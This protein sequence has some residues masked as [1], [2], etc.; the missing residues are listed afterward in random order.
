MKSE[1]KLRDPI[2]ALPQSNSSWH[3]SLQEF[4]PQPGVYPSETPK[5]VM[6]AARV[7]KLWGETALD[8]C[9]NDAEVR[10]KICRQQLKARRQVYLQTFRR[11]RA[12][13]CVDTPMPSYFLG[14]ASEKDYQIG[15]TSR[16]PLT[17]RN[18]LS[19][20]VWNHKWGW[21]LDDIKSYGG[22]DSAKR[23]YG[24][25]Q[26]G[27]FWEYDQRYAA[28]LAGGVAQYDSDDGACFVDRFTSEEDFHDIYTFVEEALL[29]EQGELEALALAEEAV[30]RDEEMLEWCVANLDGENG[31]PELKLFQE[32][33]C[34]AEDEM[35]GVC[36]PVCQS[37]ILTLGND[38]S[39]SC[40]SCCLLLD[41]DPLLSM[42]TLQN[43]TERSRQEHVHKGC[44][45]TPKFHVDDSFGSRLLL[46][47]CDG[48]GL[49]NVCL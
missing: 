34:C 9:S 28:E 12:T 18:Y 46:I 19:D 25:D 37:A 13:N 48:C 49:Y 33:K 42:T 17:H 23:L 22:D 40:S 36:C 32:G 38:F 16:M 29:K 41:P 21:E 8:K 35:G 43:C 45:Y 1:F 10:R 44:N 30:Q 39:I 15:V 5:A 4:I 20:I 31:G 11:K 2:K 27:K 3:T 47:S 26:R 6:S 14:D 24:E 7:R